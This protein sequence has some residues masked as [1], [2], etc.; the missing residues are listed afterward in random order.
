M[1][2]EQIT[3]VAPTDGQ[4][5]QPQAPSGTDGQAQTTEVPNENLPEKFKGKSAEDIAKSYIELEKKLGENSQTVNQHRQQLAQWEA[6]GKVIQSNPALYKAIETEIEQ[7]ANKDRQQSTNGQAQVRDDTRPATQAIL[8]NSFEQK[9]GIDQLPTEK[10]AQ[11]QKS[12]GE[13]IETL[14]GRSFLDIPLDRLPTYLE[15]AY[16]LVTADDNEERA[17][18]EGMIKAKQNNEAA[19]GNIQSSGVKN[20]EKT[21]TPEQQKVARRLHLTEEQY[22]KQVEEIKKEREE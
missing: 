2:E 9:Y 7:I 8:V 5:T 1:L 15:K 12:I 11:I 10:R 16:K 20:N 18:I 19:F 22:L 17:R 21:L 6:L 13:E 14:A 4:A 3:T